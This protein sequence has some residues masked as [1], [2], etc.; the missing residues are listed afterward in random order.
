MQMAANLRALYSLDQLAHN[1]GVTVRPTA[2]WL[3]GA[4]LRALATLKNSFRRAQSPFLP[5]P[6]TRWNPVQTTTLEPLGGGMY[7]LSRC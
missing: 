4:S 7:V 5:V 1:S 6:N 3:A 2:A